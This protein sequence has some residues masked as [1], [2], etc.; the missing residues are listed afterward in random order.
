MN[1]TFSLLFFFFLVALFTT[2]C[3]GRAVHKKLDRIEAFA[4]EYPDSARRVLEAMDRDLLDTPKLQARHALMLSAALSRCKIPAPDDSL[5]NLA[6]NYFRIH[7]PKKERF[8]SYYYQGRIYDDLE[9]YEAAMR[10]Y[11]QAENIHSK[12]I[13]LRYLTSLQLRKGH[14][15]SQLHAQYAAIDAYEKAGDYALQCNWIDNFAT[16][17]LG[18]AKVYFVSDQ[19]SSIDSCL[20]ALSPYLSQIKREKIRWYYAYRLYYLNAINAPKDT[21]LRLVHRIEQEYS[22]PSPGSFP[23][24]IL[25]QV[26]IEYGDFASAEQALAN[27]EK[28]LLSP[29][30]SARFQ[31]TYSELKDSLHQYQEAFH[32][33]QRFYA[34][35]T[36]REYNLQNSDTRF[37]E[38]QV[39]QKTKET[40]YVRWIIIGS[41][42]F[43]L[44]FSI[45]LY[46][47]MQSKKER[48]RIDGLYQG[49]KEEQDNLISVLQENAELQEN[50]RRLLGER[51]TALGQFLSHDKPKSLGIVSDQL[52]SL[53]ENRKE[54]LDTI[55]ML[56]AIYHPGF[57]S[58]LMDKGLSTAE[59][60]YCCLLQ[61]GF[62]T[63]EIGDVINRSSTYNISSAIRQKLGL[64]PRDTNLSIFI[65][66]L[67]RSSS[68]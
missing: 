39:V 24:N 64:G 67:Y 52:E 29:L 37:V 9:N 47:I 5:I 60:G 7:G 13:S 45:L 2:D 25:A 68:E 33:L 55:G 8:L 51:I 21:V 27:Y 58:K 12:D 65:K 32:A 28:N 26:Y 18:K 44:L 54:L 20:N 50:A 6:V 38:K 66:D 63:G 14:L 15:Y 46:S 36:L 11:I 49:L 61:L 19:Y 1:R 10:S 4:A 56:Y 17:V 40:R 3:S 31:L 23:W 41:A 16:S 48:K 22:Q 62:R 42:L 59:I 30:D 43:A 35:Q 34:F 53:T 57:V